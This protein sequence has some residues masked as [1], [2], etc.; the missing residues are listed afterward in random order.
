MSAQKTAEQRKQPPAPTDP[1]VGLNPTG[2]VR[3]SSAA[4]RRRHARRA[5]GGAA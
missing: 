5:Q 2:R 4:S 3:R 1:R